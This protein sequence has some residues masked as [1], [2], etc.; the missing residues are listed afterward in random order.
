MGNSHSA[1]ELLIR[2]TNSGLGAG[3]GSGAG[4]VTGGQAEPMAVSAMLR[5]TTVTVAPGASGRCHVLIRNRSAV[6]DQFVFSVLGAVTEWTEVKPTRVNLLPNQEVTVEL[7]FSPPRGHEVLAGD[8]PFALKVASREDVAGSVVQ[9]GTVTVTKFA[10][11]EA[12]IVPR[13]SEGRRKGRHT[14]AVDN[15]G[16][17]QF[18]VEV[19]ASDPDSRLTF[20]IRPR[21]PQTQ[22]GTANFV[23]VIARPKKYFWKGPVRQIPFA[24]KV[25]APGLDP[26]ALDGALSQKPL[27]PKRLFWL[28]ALLLALLILLI[29]VITLLL[30][31]RPVSMAGPAPT[32]PTSPS[33]TSGASATS[34][35]APVTTTAPPPPSTTATQAVIG[36]VIGSGGGGGGQQSGSATQFTIL[37]SGYPGGGA[38]LF[39]YVVPDGQNYRLASVVLANPAGDLG[40]LEIR[41]DNQALATFDLAAIHDQLTYRFPQPPTVRSGGLVTLAVSCRNAEN[42]CRPTGRFTATLVR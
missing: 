2:S 34:A 9:E 17:H 12:A 37:T 30:Q 26:V 40:S 7:T 21:A 5:A 3:R 31:Q 8:H 11:I 22:P 35:P 32:A 16:N 38:Q 33:R 29:F 24:V 13:T 14:V 1:P 39:S 15:L 6:V 36:A 10:E 23:R 19:L 20:R 27:L 18:G 42:P 28:A 4:P 25:L 41:A